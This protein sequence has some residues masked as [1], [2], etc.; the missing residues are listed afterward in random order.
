M[1]FMA[2]VTHVTDKT[3]NFVSY[4]MPHYRQSLKRIVTAMKA[5]L[6][7]LVYQYNSELKQ[8][9][10]SSYSEVHYFLECDNV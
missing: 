5:T 4:T 9:V 1:N 7:L 6:E 3:Q 10:M 8:F 2:N